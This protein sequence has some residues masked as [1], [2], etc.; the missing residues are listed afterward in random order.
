MNGKLLSSF[1]YTKLDLFSLAQN[2]RPVSILVTLSR[3][4]E[5]SLDT[6]RCCLD[7]FTRIL[8]RAQ[9]SLSQHGF[10]KGRSTLSQLLLY[11]DS[12]Y[13]SSDASV[14]VCSVYFDFKK[15]FDLV[16][17]DKLLI[18]HSIF[19]FDENI[20][21]IFKSYLSNRRQCV[22][23]DQSVSEL[24]NVIYGVPQGSVVGPLLITLFNNDI[25]D[26]LQNT[27]SLLFADDLGSKLGLKY[28]RVLVL[29]N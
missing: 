2:Y 24:K 13:R 26:N 7:T 16:P 9:I 21:L 6:F 14:S 4:F 27:E 3:V 10:I 25:S 19:G 20:L 23:L 1:L 12:L 28:F 17:H 11:I 22:K 5:R 29:F 8:V 15:A 18:K